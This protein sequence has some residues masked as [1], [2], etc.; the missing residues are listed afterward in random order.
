[1]GDS[2]GGRGRSA[3][4]GVGVVRVWGMSLIE[5]WMSEPRVRS[6]WMMVFLS[7]GRGRMCSDAR[8]TVVR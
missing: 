7:N 6:P 3:G 1:M 5:S 4:G 8:R 2:W